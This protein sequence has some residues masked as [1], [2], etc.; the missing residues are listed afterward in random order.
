MPSPNIN[1]KERVN[2]AIAGAVFALAALYFWLALEVNKLAGLYRLVLIV[3]VYLAILTF[4]ESFLGHCV[5]KNKRSAT[6]FRIHMISFFAAAV[7]S[8]ISVFL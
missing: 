2:R 1:Q 3:P 6:S 8:A 7:I 4:I 5:L